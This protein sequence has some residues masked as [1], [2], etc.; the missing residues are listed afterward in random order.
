MAASLRCD[1]W[2]DAEGKGEE[3]RERLKKR[4][5]RRSR[6]EEGKGDQYDKM[7]KHGG[8]QPATMTRKN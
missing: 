6:K 7:E 8:C 2:V 3:E 1:A 5:M 4:W